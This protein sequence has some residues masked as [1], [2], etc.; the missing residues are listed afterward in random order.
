VRFSFSEKLVEKR[1][2]VLFHRRRDWVV[3][4]Q[5]KG[6]ERTKGFVMKIFW[7][8]DVMGVVGALRTNENEKKT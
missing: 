7:C 3:V 1:V 4:N 6:V 8:V 2:L 5:R